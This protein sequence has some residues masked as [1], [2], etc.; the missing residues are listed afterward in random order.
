[1]AFNMEQRKE[2]TKLSPENTNR[3]RVNPDGTITNLEDYTKEEDLR[4]VRE[5][6]NPLK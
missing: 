2:D 4:Q 1:M 3:L 5:E 6:G